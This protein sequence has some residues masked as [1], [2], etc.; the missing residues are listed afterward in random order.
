MAA[1]KP[2]H[3]SLV[4]FP[5][6]T[7][8]I[9]GYNRYE[10]RSLKGTR[11]RGDPGMR[12]E[13]GARAR[14]RKPHPGSFGHHR[15]GTTTGLGGAFPGLG[16]AGAG[17]ARLGTRG[18]FLPVEEALQDRTS[19]LV[20]RKPGLKLRPRAERPNGK[21]RGGTPTGERVP[22]DARRARMARRFDYTSAGVPPSFF[23]CL[24]AHAGAHKGRPYDKPPLR[25]GGPCG[26]P[27]PRR[28]A[29]ARARSRRENC[30]LFRHCRALTRQSM[31][32]SRLPRRAP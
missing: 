31:R 21:N 20:P 27:G 5:L 10:S 17:N 16:L 3:D 2:G 15:T 12:S 23:V 1:D 26:R 22:Q 19:R 4:S 7:C 11:S 28:F 9:F 13:C 30:L 18:L 32:L 29:K 6:T 8:P 14:S 24:M 25:R